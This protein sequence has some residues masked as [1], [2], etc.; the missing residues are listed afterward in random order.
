MF[1]PHFPRQILVH[2]LCVWFSEGKDFPGV[3]DRSVEQSEL[4]SVPLVQRLL[5]CSSFEVREITVWSPQNGELVNKI[6]TVQR[7]SVSI[8]W[9]AVE[10]CRGCYDYLKVKPTLDLKGFVDEPVITL[11][12]TGEKMLGYRQLSLSFVCWF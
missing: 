1:S 7:P 3:G 4:E 10:E 2:F 5:L 11:G 8:A 6:T 9:S 12:P